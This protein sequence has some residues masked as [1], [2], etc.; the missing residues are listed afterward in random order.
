LIFFCFF[1]FQ[2]NFAQN[3]TVEKSFFS[4]Q[5]SILGTWITNES[6]LT[7]QIALKSELGLDASLFGGD[8]YKN[9]GFVLTPTINLE[10]RWYYNLEKRSANNRTLKNNNANFI[11]LAASY[12]PDWFVISNYNNVKVVNQ[13]SI[14]PKWG[15]RRNIAKSNFNYELGIGLGIRHYFFNQNYKSKNNNEAALDLHL[16]LGYTF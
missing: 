14:I 11:T 2:S 16:R 9:T 4:F 6:K 1:I 10:P 15:I 5:T 13:I 3:A 12:H 8:Y 7:N